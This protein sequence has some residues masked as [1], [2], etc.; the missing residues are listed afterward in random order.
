MQRETLPS[1]VSDGEQSLE[2][3]S[4][5]VAGLRACVCVCTCTPM[6]G[7]VYTFTAIKGLMWWWKSKETR[8]AQRLLHPIFMTKWNHL[9]V[10]VKVTQSCPTLC[11]HKNSPGQNTGMGSLSLLQGIFPTQGTNLGLQ[12]CRQILYQLSRKGSPRETGDNG[13]TNLLDRENPF[14]YT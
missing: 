4:L 7:L 13:C 6:R 1:A 8:Y 12:H 5:S 10:K 3:S 14:I 11:N 9:K 2:G